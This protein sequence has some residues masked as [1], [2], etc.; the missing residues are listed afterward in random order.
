MS[1]QLLVTKKNVCPFIQKYY[2]ECYCNSLDSQ[3]IEKVIS[4]CG[5]SY[6]QCQVYQVRF[7]SE[8]VLKS[9][10]YAQKIY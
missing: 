5:G 8:S 7:S 2:E 9:G 1:A 4:F 6:R 3:D 10:V